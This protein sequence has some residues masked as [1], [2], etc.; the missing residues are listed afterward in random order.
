[1]MKIRIC[2]LFA[3]TVHVFLPTAVVDELFRAFTQTKI[4]THPGN[5]SASASSVRLALT[6]AELRTTCG[7]LYDRH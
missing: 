6:L 2:F 5:E 7:S 3:A 1:M 4:S